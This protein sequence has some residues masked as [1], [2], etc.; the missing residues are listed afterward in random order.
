MM[1]L[2]KALIFLGIYAVL[3]F[4]YELSGWELLKPICGVDESVFEHLKIGFWAYFFTNI[5]EYFFA[6]KKH[7]FWYPR[8][9]ST[10]LL[11]WFIVLIWYM[12]PVFF[13]HVESLAVDLSWAFV[14]TFLAAILSEILEKDLERNS[15]G[16]ALKIVIVVLFIISIIFYTAFSYEKPWIDVFTKH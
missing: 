2:W 5:I 3:H 11:P 9:L 10:V 8:I 7:G 14:V 16:T 13:G 1:M 15:L 6:K 12:L 4:G